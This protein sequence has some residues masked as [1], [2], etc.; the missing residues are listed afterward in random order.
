[1]T[2]RFAAVHE[3]ASTSREI[4]AA[5][6][7][8]RDRAAWLNPTPHAI[9]VYASCSARGA[10]AG[11]DRRQD[12]QAWIALCTITD[13]VRR[14]KKRPIRPLRRREQSLRRAR[15]CRAP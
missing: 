3:C 4:E 6:T 11:S 5:A 9:A 10:P 1:M 15:L 14:S 12:R 8:V 13:Q 2:M 7:L